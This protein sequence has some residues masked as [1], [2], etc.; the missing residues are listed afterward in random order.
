MW[1]KCNLQQKCLFINKKYQRNDKK[2][3][4][5]VKAKK[6]AM[7]IDTAAVLRSYLGKNAFIQSYRSS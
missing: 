7:V 6:V 2:I 1:G 4:S 5:T 3:T